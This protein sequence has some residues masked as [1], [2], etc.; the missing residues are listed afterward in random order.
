MVAE[1]EVSKLYAYN[2]NPNMAKPPRRLPPTFQFND[3]LRLQYAYKCIQ[4]GTDMQQCAVG[5]RKGHIKKYN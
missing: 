5:G 4:R 1:E 3:G 2:F